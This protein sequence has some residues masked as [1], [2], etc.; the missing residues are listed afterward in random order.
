M[1]KIFIVIIGFLLSVSL[2]QCETPERLFI[3]AN[4][5]Y[6]SGAYSQAADLYAHLIN[7][8]QIKTSA[9]YY[10]LG[11]CFYRTG[12]MGRAI[13]Y[14]EKAL[15]LAPRSP[16]IRQNLVFARGQTID[17]IDSTIP[18]ISAVFSRILSYFTLNEVSWA[19]WS[20]AIVFLFISGLILN[21]RASSRMIQG[22][23]YVALPL[24]LGIGILFALKLY[25]YAYQPQGV[26]IAPKVEVK[27]GPG[28]GF[29]TLFALHDGT[30]FS[31]TG[32]RQAD[33]VRLELDNGNNGWL[34][35]DMVSA[36]NP[37]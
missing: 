34:P 18:F 17:R 26:V 20:I 9:L 8:Q 32:D 3:Q 7:Q 5:R 10:N 6:Q 14:Y 27:S 15:L 30:K 13:L 2:A 19:F 33:W 16:E 21:R 12:Q 24:I 4:Q 11:N 1:K 25:M 36:I 28:T 35:A 37:L 23:V 31:Y 22:Y 29:Q